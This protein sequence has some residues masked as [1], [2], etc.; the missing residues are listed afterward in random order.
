MRRENGFEPRHCFATLAIAVLVCAAG[1]RPFS[2]DFWST[3]WPLQTGEKAPADGDKKDGSSEAQDA[4]ALADRLANDAWVLTLPDPLRGAPRWRWRNQAIEIVESPA[5]PT[6]D[7][8]APLLKDRRM[9]V[10][11]NAAIMLARQGDDAGREVLLRT[12]R[13]AELRLPLRRAAA[14]ALA[15]IAGPK[16]VED[17]TGLIDALGNEAEMV[18]TAYAPELHADLLRLLAEHASP[19][20]NPRYQRALNSRSADVRRAAVAAWQRET[21]AELPLEVMDHRSDPDTGVRCEAI[22]TIAARR[23]NGAYDAIESML[24]DHHLDV[25]VVAIGA[26]AE[27]GDPRALK[28]LEAERQREGEELRAAAT[29]GLLKLQPEQ[30]LP[31]ALAD[32]SWRV[33]SVVADALAQLPDRN[34]R[35][36]AEQLLLDRSLEVQ[37]RVVAS[38]DAWPLA[39]AGPL[40]L[41]AYEQSAYGTRQAATDQLRRRW[42]AAEQLSAD[43]PQERRVTVLAELRKQWS[44]EFGQV[45]RG[46]LAETTP[47][48]VEAARPELAERLDRDLQRLEHDTSAVGTRRVLDELRKLGPELLSACDQWTVEHERAL[49][50][51]MYVEVLKDRAAEF[52]ALVNLASQQVTQRRD[53]AQQL[54]RVASGAALRDCTNA[55]MLELGRGEQDALVCRA[56]LLTASYR[57]GPAGEQLAYAYMSHPAAEV[58]HGA[59]ELLSAHARPGHAT[60]LLPA[61]DDDNAWVVRGAVRALGQPGMRTDPRKLEPLLVSPDKTLR[62]DVATALARLG[63]PSGVLA[64]ER[65][66]A[67][68]DMDI[69][70]QAAAA[71]GTV[72]G[73]QFTSTLVRMLDD[74][75]GVRSAALE[76]LPRVVGSD[77]AKADGGAIAPDVAQRTR[78]WR[79]WWQ[80]QSATRVP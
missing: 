76:A 15:A 18:A 31:L 22:R 45:D 52:A 62:I 53:G 26:L 57:A 17:L 56:L 77:V 4:A 11:T 20:G 5:P 79:E 9:M 13:A 78:L 8:L 28:A 10:A 49:P 32:K 38:L 47:P 64:L 74:T 68:N 73:E 80:R 30:T 16:A 59:C 48:P 43:A 55:R 7:Q 51:S 63:A 24:H 61:L 42:P 71:M 29:K 39:S 37:R 41:M 2:T 1:C 70:R 66:A 58:R 34:G 33:R 60:V 23:P 54:A 44:E 46:A 36:A 35:H 65:L 19:A 67:D 69:R 25:R 3:R 6:P 40:L 12:T 72:G 75:I 21:K 50:A 27:T 14:E